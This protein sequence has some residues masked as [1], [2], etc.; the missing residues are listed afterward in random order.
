MYEIWASRMCDTIVCTNSSYGVWESN[1]PSGAN[2]AKGRQ[3]AGVTGHTQVGFVNIL[4]IGP[5]SA[6]LSQAKQ[7]PDTEGGP[8]AGKI[9]KPSVL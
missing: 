4:Q 8:A 7:P 1:S 3:R 6:Q 9:P 5:A 2:A